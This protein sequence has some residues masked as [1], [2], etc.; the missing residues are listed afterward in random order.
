MAVVIRTGWEGGPTGQEIGVT[1]IDPTAEL[2]GD[3]GVL[4]YAS[5]A[6]APL[7]GNYSLYC[8]SAPGNRFIKF[9]V[10]DTELWMRE[11]IYI[12]GSS[13]DTP[14]RRWKSDTEVI[15][16]L[17]ITSTGELRI[18]NGRD[19]IAWTTSNSYIGEWVR[20]QWRV[21]ST[22]GT[23]EQEIEVFS[24]ANLNGTNTMTDY[25]GSGVVGAAEFAA[26]IT[27]LNMGSVTIGNS[28]YYADAL[29]VNDAQQP[30]PRT[31]ETVAY[32]TVDAYTGTAGS[33]LFTFTNGST[34]A[35]SY[36][37][38]FGDGATSTSTDPTHTYA[39]SGDYLVSLIAFGSSLVGGSAEYQE[40]ISVSPA[41]VTGT[42]LSFEDGPDGDNVDETGWPLQSGTGVI[43][44]T[45]NKVVKGTYAARVNEGS[46]TA[47][48]RIIS[49]TVSPSQ[50]IIAFREYVTINALPNDPTPMV[51][52]TAR[53]VGGNV[54]CRLGYDQHGKWSLFQRGTNLAGD[55]SSLSV[56]AVSRTSLLRV[57]WKINTVTG[58]QRARLYIGSNAHGSTADI[59]LTGTCDVGT[60]VAQIDFGACTEATGSYTM[61]EFAYD[62]D[63]VGAVASPNAHSGVPGVAFTADRLTASL[64]NAIQFTD[65]STGTP[66]SY[67]WN[68]GDGTTSTSASPSKT[69][70]A[71][72]T[73]TVTHTATNGSGVSASRTLTVTVI[74]VDK[75]HAGIRIYKSGL[76]V[77]NLADNVI[78]VRRNG[79]WVKDTVP[80]VY[81]NGEWTGNRVPA[82]LSQP[83]TLTITV[84]TQEP[85]TSSSDFTGD[86][87]L[88]S[89]IYIGWT[90]LDSS[91]SRTRFQEMY[92]F[93][94]DL[95][96]LSAGPTWPAVSNLK[97]S[98]YR[99]FNT[100]SDKQSFGSHGD[101]QWSDL[102]LAAANMGW[103]S[104]SFDVHTAGVM[105]DAYTGSYDAWFNSLGTFLQ[106]CYDRY[107]TAICI[108]FNNEPDQWDS[109]TGTAASPL[110]LTRLR[111]LA[112]YAY[113]YL[114][115]DRGVDDNAFFIGTP[116]I[117][118][119]TGYQTPTR[120]TKPIRLTQ[121]SW[122]SQAERGDAIYY[123]YPDWKGTRTGWASWDDPKAVDFYQPGEM[124]EWGYGTGP[125]CKIVNINTYEKTYEHSDGWSS[126]L[127]MRNAVA[128]ATG[129]AG[130]HFV[131]NKALYGTSTPVLPWAHANNKGLPVQIGEWGYGVYHPKPSTSDNSDPSA[132]ADVYVNDYIPDLI[133]NNVIAVNKWRYVRDIYNGSY[134][135]SGNDTFTFHL[136]VRDGSGAVSGTH[137]WD[138]NNANSK[139]YAALFGQSYSATPLPWP[140]GTVK[141]LSPQV[142]L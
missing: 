101:A 42:E 76:Q 50:D 131:F 67:D 35:D 92:D 22:T 12:S 129:R 16:G 20:V 97:P 28:Q 78:K 70:T 40:L 116:V 71:A 134:P 127:A 141:P 87:G 104:A 6:P 110:A 63:W 137:R 86:P 43:Q 15:C 133:N 55:T 64:G 74:N 94:Q 7:Y 130:N 138:N 119:Q 98:A 53:K 139:A 3:A 79:V 58:V 95:K 77:I 23:G 52:M 66:S 91:Y 45:T 117:F 140:D 106:D 33:T 125:V 135:G 37:W 120:H 123:Y 109:G 103:V 60:D 36:E 88:K 11:F 51:I 19:T 32:F 136:I 114:R 75:E 34:D 2:A 61:D 84:T 124:D 62:A 31:V 29:I 99:S 26:G 85:T 27:Q 54:L 107:G 9:Y 17:N 112:R 46:E 41:A 25:E 8:D 113:F 118:N 21:A 100:L 105:Q 142:G 59:V 69:Y 57:E 111:R 72:G 81:V 121:T 5:D 90:T 68:F 108:D 14:I 80:R 4:V 49:R 83:P 96:T 47:G 24:G 1:L 48:V 115:D 13:Q 38:S 132:T 18:T 30:G 44:Y 93:R 89:K 10:S 39:D 65:F 56:A 128:S 82:T 102:R 122:P 126:L 73:Y